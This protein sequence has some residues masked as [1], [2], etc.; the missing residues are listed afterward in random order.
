MK[1]VKFDQPVHDI[2]EIIKVNSYLYYW[3]AAVAGY[4]NLI[5]NKLFQNTIVQRVIDIQI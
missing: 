2:N 5:Q 4:D 1:Y 3:N